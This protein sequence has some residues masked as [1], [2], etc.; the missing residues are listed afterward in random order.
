MASAFQYQFQ[1]QPPPLPR[2]T[3]GKRGP[4]GPLT[5][6]SSSEDEDCDLKS[7]TKIIDALPSPHATQI[8]SV[9]NPI[10][11][12]SN[13][14]KVTSGYHSSKKD[15]I[16][17]VTEN[18]I[19]HSGLEA[20]TSPSSPRLPAASPPHSQFAHELDHDYDN[21]SSPNSSTA[22]GPIYI[23]PP[24]F[25]HHAQEV[26]SLKSKLVR[27]KSR[28]AAVISLKDGFKQQDQTPTKV[29]PRR[30]EY[31][32]FIIPNTFASLNCYSE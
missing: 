28:P 29:K 1:P 18:T 8:I 3:G 17:L 6:S 4:S 26:E 11:H 30:G 16:T 22:S 9:S 7:T 15:T 23:R 2:T 25:K 27:K 19:S 31:M 21:V 10:F 12:I 5:V 32:I 24:G 13:G 20:S 14:S